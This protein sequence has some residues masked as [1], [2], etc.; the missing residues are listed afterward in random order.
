MLKTEGIF[1]WWIF[2]V[3]E[4]WVFDDGRLV[5]R[6]RVGEGIWG[7]KLKQLWTKKC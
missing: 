4:E 1:E 3:L 2:S 7:N 6:L 5:V